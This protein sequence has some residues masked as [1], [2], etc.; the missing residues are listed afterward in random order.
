MAALKKLAQIQAA[1]LGLE[2]IGSPIEFYGHNPETGVGR[3]YGGTLVRYQCGDT[4]LVVTLAP[5]TS[6]DVS[7]ATWVKVLSTPRITRSIA[8][9][10]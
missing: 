6:L 5:D 4:H 10:S 7:G 8:D 2:H 1:E 9:A 3:V